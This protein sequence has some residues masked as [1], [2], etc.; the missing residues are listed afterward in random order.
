M[1]KEATGLGEK[2]KRGDLRFCVPALL[3]VLLPEVR[4][5]F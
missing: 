5:S 4:M 3:P 2:V 1:I